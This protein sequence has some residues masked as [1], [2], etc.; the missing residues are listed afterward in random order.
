MTGPLAQPVRC[1][2]FIPMPLPFSVRF[3]ASDIAPPR[4]SRCGCRHRSGLGDFVSTQT[5]GEALNVAGSGTQI[6]SVLSSNLPVTKKVG[7][8]ITSVGAAIAPFNPLIGGAVA[9]VGAITGLFSGGCGAPCTQ[10]ATAEQVFEAAADNILH[11]AQAGYISG[12]QAA[13]LIQ[14]ILAEGQQQFAQLVQNN[15][16]AQGGL[17][18]MTSVIGNVLQA[19]ASIGNATQAFN[20]Q[21]AMGTFIAPGASGWEPG[22]AQAAYNLAQQALASLGLGSSTAGSPVT[23]ASSIGTTVSSLTGSPGLLLAGAGLLVLFLVM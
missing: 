17:R 7:G 9:L 10:S 22:A 2:H 5:A 12:S 4:P 11:V 3:M 23:A 19:A 14:Q 21:A 1:G 18:N 15:P 13:G 6:F 16:K 8:T 20:M